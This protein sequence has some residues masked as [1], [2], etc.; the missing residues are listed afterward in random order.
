MPQ[1]D[2]DEKEKEP[3]F[4]PTPP[5]LLELVVD[6]LFVPHA[7]ATMTTPT[8][9]R[10]FTTNASYCAVSP[11]HVMSAVEP[12]WAPPVP[13]KRMRRLSFA[14]QFPTIAGLPTS[15]VD[16]PSM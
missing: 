5:V 14:G 13:T 12:I 9:S 2:D 10:A 16:A 8:T 15:G 3:V 11:E 6:P 7:A 4:P 1:P